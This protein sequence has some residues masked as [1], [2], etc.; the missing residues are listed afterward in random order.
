[1][2]AP[3]DMDD[4]ALMREAGSLAAFWGRVLAGRTMV[5][6]VYG[7]TPDRIEDRRRRTLFIAILRR[8][9]VAARVLLRGA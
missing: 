5:G 6:D 4:D 8:D 7:W 2:T 3:L 1:M 9:W